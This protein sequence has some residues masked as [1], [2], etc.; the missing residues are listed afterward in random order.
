[1]IGFPAGYLRPAG[2]AITEDEACALTGDPFPVKCFGRLLASAPGLN[3]T[4]PLQELCAEG[5][6]LVVAG[7][8]AA[9]PPVDEE[10]SVEGP[11]ADQ[12]P[13]LCDRQVATSE[14]A[15]LL[16]KALLL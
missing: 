15:T 13:L 9:S 11:V 16:G 5:G 7:S 3:G 6:R 4:W 2:T 8:V 12:A 10:L 14:K 1:M